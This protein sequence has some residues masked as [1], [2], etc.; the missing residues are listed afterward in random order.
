MTHKI[1]NRK[2]YLFTVFVWL[3]GVLLYGWYYVSDMMA[4]LAIHP[5]A[6]FYANTLGFQI[7]AFMMTRG[8][9]AGLILGAVLL[10]EA[11]KIEK[12]NPSSNQTR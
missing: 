12:P 11:W 7:I 3:I 9:V 8:L 4:Y 6:D 5:S 10:V 2:I 1:P